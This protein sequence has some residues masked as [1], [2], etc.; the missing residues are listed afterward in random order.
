[1]CYLMEAASSGQKHSPG[2]KCLIQL[3]KST[4]EL[5]CKTPLFNSTAQLT[6]K[7]SHV[8]LAVTIHIP[9]FVNRLNLQIG[10]FRAVN[11]E[12]ALK[13]TSFNPL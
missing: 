10:V 6:N 7:L 5:Q 8:D 2:P 9:Q 1:M 12:S 11:S 13:I 4:I 3:F